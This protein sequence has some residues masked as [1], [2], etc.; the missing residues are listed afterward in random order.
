MKDKKPFVEPKIVADKQL[1]PPDRDFP[2]MP[3]VSGSGSSSDAADG[4]FPGDDGGDVKLDT[5]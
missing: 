4:P 2:L 1:E 3:L 5:D